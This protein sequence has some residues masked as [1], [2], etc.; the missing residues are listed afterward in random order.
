M[1][2][3]LYEIYYRFYIK[4]I[5][6]LVMGSDNMNNEKENKNAIIF[7]IWFGISFVLISSSIMLQNMDLMLV[8]VGQYFLVFGIYGY[9]KTKNIATFV[10][11][12]VGIYFI[13]ARILNA[14]F[15][16]NIFYL[17]FLFIFVMMFAVGVVYIINYKKRLIEILQ[18]Y[19]INSKL[20]IKDIYKEKEWHVKSEYICNNETI[21]YEESFE[22]KKH[23]PYKVGKEVDILVNK[24]DNNE[25]IFLKEKE[26]MQKVNKSIL[27]LYLYTS[28]GFIG[29][30][31]TLLIGLNIIKI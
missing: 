27:I 24:K 17:L 1:L 6:I 29:I 22:F 2:Y 15:N 19:T 11:I 18:N 5:L 8:M 14:L 7:L 25:F 21:N 3:I 20:K 9:K 28:I 12:V 4:Y 30:I 23:I 10:A 13:M 26:S 31:F 16:I